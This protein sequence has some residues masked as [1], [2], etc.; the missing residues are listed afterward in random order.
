MKH[1]QEL[2][3]SEIEMNFRHDPRSHK[4]SIE[5]IEGTFAKSGYQ[6]DLVGV[7]IEITGSTLSVYFSYISDADRER[8]IA[9]FNADGIEVQS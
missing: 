8:I 6:I 3:G 9:A 7:V 1:I 5:Y 2:I 4:G